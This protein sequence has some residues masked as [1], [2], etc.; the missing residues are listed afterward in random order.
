MLIKDISIV[1]IYFNQ[2]LSNS[3]SDYTNCQRSMIHLTRYNIAQKPR[4]C[5]L[6]THVMK[7]DIKYL[8]EISE[9]FS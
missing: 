9:P 3:K 6:L 2:G 1:Q 7:H 8:R 4:D 5:G